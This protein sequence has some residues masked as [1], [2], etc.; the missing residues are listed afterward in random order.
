[1]S[2]YEH[3]DFMPKDN[4]DTAGIQEESAD[5]IDA[6]STHIDNAPTPTDPEIG[7]IEAE[8][9]IPGWTKIVSAIF[10]PF[11]IPTYMMVLAMWITPLGQI[12]DNIRIGATLMILVLTDWGPDIFRVVISRFGKSSKKLNDTWR[13]NLTDGVFIVSQGIAAYYLYSVH[14]PGWLVQ[15]M[16]ASAV[17][18]LSYLI[19]NN[20]TI[21]CRHTVTMGILTAAS[22]YLFRNNLSGLPP[23]LFIGAL[24]VLTGLV[25]SARMMLERRTILQISLGFVIGFIIAYIIMN[26]PLIEP[27]PF[28]R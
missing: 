19:I 1:M 24:I 28:L 16:I 11:L 26:L 6:S 14:A 17:A 8:E 5:T 20:F 25:G 2:K 4:P 13:T 12:N 7:V 23:T 15:F 21:I 10:N 22:F 3:S 27:N 9:P 18:V